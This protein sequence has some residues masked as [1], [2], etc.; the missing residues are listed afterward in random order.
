MSA[1]LHVRSLER[2]GE[3]AGA[4]VLARVDALARRLGLEHPVRV[5]V[6]SIADGPATVGWLRP[7]ILIPPAVVM[8]ITPAQLDALLAH[9]IAHIRRHDYLINMLQMAVETVFFY[10]PAI[11]WAS[12]RIR[13]EREIC[14]DEA[15]VAASGDPYGYAE[16]LTRIAREVMPRF[17]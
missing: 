10:H 12:K 17:R 11:W 15:A 5:I 7:V 1:G 4:D 6:A 9:E 14:C 13:I 8:G 16:A 3:P 2:R